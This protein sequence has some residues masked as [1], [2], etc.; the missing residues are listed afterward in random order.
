[1][2]DSPRAG[3]QRDVNAVVDAFKAGLQF[4]PPC[5]QPTEFRRALRLAGF[6]LDERDELDTPEFTFPDPT[7]EDDLAEFP[8]E[9]PDDE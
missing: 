7:G 8:E 2:N 1:M 6:P 3:F 9:D 4:D 5:I